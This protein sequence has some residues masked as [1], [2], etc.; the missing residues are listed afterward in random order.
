ME[1]TCILVIVSATERSKKERSQSV[2]KSKPAKTP[3]A[4]TLP[5]QLLLPFTAPSDKYPP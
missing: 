3:V 5:Q 1:T 2:K 4:K